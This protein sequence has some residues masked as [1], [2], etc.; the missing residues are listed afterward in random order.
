MSSGRGISIVLLISLFLLLSISFAVGPTGICSGTATVGCSGVDSIS[1]TAAAGCSLHASGNNCVTKSGGWDYYLHSS[2]NP[3]TSSSPSCHYYAWYCPNGVECC[4]GLPQFQCE[5]VNSLAN[6]TICYWNSTNTCSGTF[7]GSCSDFDDNQNVCTDLGCTWTS[8]TSGNGP[9][10]PNITTS[11]DPAYNYSNLGASTFATDPDGNTVYYLFQWSIGGAMLKTDGNPVGSSGTPQTQSSFNCSAYPT[12]AGGVNVTVKVTAW[13]SSS[14]IETFCSGAR[15]FDCSQYL[16]WGTTSGGYSYPNGCSQSAPT[17]CQTTDTGCDGL[18]ADGT[19][20]HDGCGICPSGVETY[21]CD[22]TFSCL[23]I[24]EQHM[25]T[26]L[27]CT[28]HGGT[29]SNILNS[30][31]SKNIWITSLVVNSPPVASIESA[32]ATASPTDSISVGVKGTDP[33]H[34]NVTL[35]IQFRNEYNAVLKSVSCPQ[36]PSPYLCSLGTYQCSPWNC[37]L[38]RNISVWAQASDGSLDSAWVSE[39]ITIVPAPVVAPSGDLSSLIPLAIAVVLS[40]YAIAY[41]AGQFFNL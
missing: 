4:P 15:T 1:C 24:S 27:G 38:G 36:A 11:P 33:D 23:D 32:P 12:C 35:A 10:T 16:E 3:A 13:S 19:P 29:P 9:S 21:S 25:C 5:S 14:P 18:N 30:S 22:G 26:S 37:T 2:C 20:C 7:T 6:T 41:M 31:A 8:S 34:D 39:N 28:W 17:F 40:G